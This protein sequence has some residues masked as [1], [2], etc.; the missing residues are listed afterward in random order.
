MSGPTRNLT[1]GIVIVAALVAFVP[2]MLALSNCLGLRGVHK[3]WFVA[4]DA[5]SLVHFSDHI[6]IARYLD[7]TFFKTP[8]V[9]HSHPDSPASLIDV[10]RRFEV[11]EALKG[12]FGAGDTALVGW[13]AGY[14][15]RNEDEEGQ[16]VPRESGSFSPGETYVLFLTRFHGRRPPDLELGTRVWQPR[17]GLGVAHV[18]AQGR[19]SFETDARYQAALKDMDLE[20]VDGS[21]APFELTLAGVREMVA[22]GPDPA[23]P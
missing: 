3:D 18:D 15:E 5:G 17:S 20:P 14:Y 2:T 12:D 1:I 7:E 16:F 6:V 23:P 21:G 8:N 19:L 4:V 22:T 10:Y 13:A 9:P 11:V